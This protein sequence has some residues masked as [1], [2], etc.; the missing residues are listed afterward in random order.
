MPDYSIDEF[1][2]RFPNLAKEMLEG[3]GSQLEL[4]LDRGLSDPWHNYL[5]NAIDYVRRCR[6]LEEVREVLDYLV[7]RREIAEEEA[8][9]ILRN[10]EERGLE[11]YGKRKES[12]YYYKKAVEYWRA[13]ARL[14]RERLKNRPDAEDLE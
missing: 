8:R 1:R 11:Y 13:R 3:E 7:R 10:V 14:L 12:D 5:P 4:S 2:R 9:E 6:S